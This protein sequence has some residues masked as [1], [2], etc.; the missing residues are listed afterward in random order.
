MQL[1]KYGLK[2]GQL[3]H[4][5]NVSNGLA[6]GCRCPSCGGRLEAHQGQKNQAH[7][8]HYSSADCEHGSES[9]LHIMAKNIIAKTKTVYIPY[10]PKNIYDWSARGKC[11]KFENAY[12]EKA[13]SSEIRCDVLL[14]TGDVFLNVEIKVTHEVDVSKKLKLY[15]ENLRTIEIDLSDIIDDF[16]ELRIRKMIESGVHTELIYS[17]KAREIHAKWLLGEWKDI[18]RDRIGH[19]YVKKCRYSDGKKITYFASMGEAY[20]SDHTSAECFYC[21]RGNFIPKNEEATHMLCCGLFDDLDF[22]TID[23]IVDV[24]RKND[25]VQYAELV[26]N[27]ERV[28]YGKNRKV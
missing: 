13:V 11:Y 9:A 6:C 19:Q 7:F 1:L 2:D 24:K 17:P 22:K 4:I 26:V 27:G 12:I 18:F 25:I 5:D 3:V 10:A 20:R 15:N 28:T 21:N 8:K 16:N 14:Q 23:K